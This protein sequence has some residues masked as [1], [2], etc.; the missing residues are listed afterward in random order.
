L[1][2]KW[3]WLLA[4]SLEFERFNRGFWLNLLVGPFEIASDRPRPSSNLRET[5]R[6]VRPLERWVPVTWG[7]FL[8]LLITGPWLLPGYFFGTDFP[9]PRHFNFPDAPT[10][11]AGLQTALAVLGLVLPGDL[12]GKLFVIGTLFV[13]ALTSYAAAPV[14]G[15][16]PRAVA[17]LIYIFNPFVYDRLA[18]GQLTVLAG[19]AVLPWFASSLRD[20]LREPGPKRA[21][22][23]A[24]AFVVVSSLDVHLA[25]IAVLMGVIVTIVYVLAELRSRAN[26]ARRSG[27]LLLAGLIAVV[28]SAYWVIP[29]IRGSGWEAQVLANISQGDLHAFRTVPDPNLGLLPNVIG[30]Y[31]FWAEQVR[32]FPSLKGYVPGWPI[33]IAMILLLAIVGAVTTVIRGGSEI[34]LD[35]KWVLGLV[36]ACIPAT[37]L[38]LG[39]ADQHVTPLVRWLDN[40]FP[41]YRGMR[42]ASKW[43]ALLALAYSQLASLGSKALMDWTGKQVKPGQGRELAV[44]LLT[45]IVLALPLYYGNGL[46]YGMHGQFQASAYPP[47]WYAADRA[48]SSDPHPGRTLFLPWHGYMAFSFIRNANPVVAS[49]A[50]FFFSMPIVA[51][52]DLEIPGVAPPAGDPDQTMVS[53]LVAAGDRGEWAAMLASRNFKYILL[54][55]D[56]DWR[57]YGY[58]DAQ[59]GLTLVEDYGSIALYRNALWHGQ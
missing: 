44:A 6:T 35:R 5:T 22:M 54:A 53:K 3:R 37:I 1:R 50:P 12:V 38:Y 7:L 23:T 19:Y 9:G 45:A 8:S 24:A 36:L 20:L 14:Q 26:L 40:T 4:L 41:P 57:S 10:S 58:I 49:P 11:Y 27:Y 18:Y 48:I 17:S 39:V 33:V 28:A 2:S 25:V 46:L 34:H 51:S 47:G 15:F 42:D 52:R 32:R 31:G 56:V 29:M 30:L 43:A 21:L 59:A 13:A 16:V 55:R